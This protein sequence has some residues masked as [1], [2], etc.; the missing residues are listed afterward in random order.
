MAIQKIDVNEIKEK[1]DAFIVDRVRAEKISVAKEYLENLCPKIEEKLVFNAIYKTNALAGK[2]AIKYLD[3]RIAEDLKGKAI[4]FLLDGELVIVRGEEDIE[5]A[6]DIILDKVSGKKRKKKQQEIEQANRLNE[7]IIKSQKLSVEIEKTKAKS[8]KTPKIML[9][10]TQKTK[11]EIEQYQIQDL[12]KRKRL[13]NSLDDR[14]K[15]LRKVEKYNEKIKK[16]HKQPQMEPPKTLS[17]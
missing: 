10:G 16:H 13:N 7:Q 1:V 2:K 9:Q 5:D 11:T 8:K 6:M 4:S 17:R 3:Q 12:K 14:V 15:V